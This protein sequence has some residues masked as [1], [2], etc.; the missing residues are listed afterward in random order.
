MSEFCMMNWPATVFT[1]YAGMARNKV[2]PAAE[3]YIIARRIEA[4][5]KNMVVLDFHFN[6]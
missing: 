5:E 6:V 4:T 1:E 2:P 3:L